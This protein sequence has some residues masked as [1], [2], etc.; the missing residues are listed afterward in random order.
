LGRARRRVTHVGRERVDDLAAVADEE[1]EM[2]ELRVAGKTDA[3]ERGP[4]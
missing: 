1:V 2:G 3:A 4:G